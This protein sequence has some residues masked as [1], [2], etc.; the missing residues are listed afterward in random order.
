MIDVGRR[1]RPVMRDAGCTTGGR[2]KPPRAAVFLGVARYPP[3]WTAGSGADHRRRLHPRRRP[4]RRADPARREL[5]VAE[6]RRG[7]GP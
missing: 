1:S 6:E 7:L 2:G 3:A 5:S 4:N